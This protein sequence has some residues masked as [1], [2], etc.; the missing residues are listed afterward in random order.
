MDE[1]LKP[2][3]AIV[4]AAISQLKIDPVQARTESQGLWFLR[5]GSASV[6]VKINTVQ[7]IS[8]TRRILLLLSKIMEMPHNNR[9][10]F[11][12][13]LLELNFQFVGEKFCRYED[14]IYLVLA[15][16]IEGLDVAEVHQMLTS[17]GLVADRFD[18][19]LRER[20]GEKP[21]GQPSS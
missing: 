5:R 16:D 7:N 4:E 10:I 13:T 17:F 2:Y 15:R 1:K 3:L 6:E 12:S 8:G 21:S 14:G 19:S 20:F 18:D 9:E 11:L